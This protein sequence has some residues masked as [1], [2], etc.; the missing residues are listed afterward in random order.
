M[1]PIALQ[2]ELMFVVSK[3][4]CTVVYLNDPQFGTIPIFTRAIS[5]LDL[6]A[7]VLSLVPTG[8]MISPNA[9]HKAYG[10]PVPL[11]VLEGQLSWQCLDMKMEQRAEYADVVTRHNTTM[12]PEAIRHAT[13][14]WQQDADH[15]NSLS[16]FQW[17]QAMSQVSRTITTTVANAAWVA[18]YAKE[19]ETRKLADC[20]CRQMCE[21]MKKY[22]RHR[23]VLF[24]LFCILPLLFVLFGYIIS[25]FV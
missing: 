19:K 18:V 14:Q 23:N 11:S 15:I 21:N 17:Y 24:V 9:F 3:D 10:L 25:I 8:R 6:A 5:P 16:F 12:F 20:V 4:E 2:N 13:E 22:N 7:H 1:N